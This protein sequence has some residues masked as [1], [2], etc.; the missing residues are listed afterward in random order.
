[1]KN[2]LARPVQLLAVI[3]LVALLVGFADTGV[4]WGQAP[5]PPASGG[6]IYYF[7]N[8]SA[9]GMPRVGLTCNGK[10]DSY[11]ERDFQPRE[12]LWVIG[13]ANQWVRLERSVSGSDIM[14]VG[15]PD[16]QA[17]EKRIPAT[18]DN[19]GVFKV[20]FNLTSEN[21][22]RLAVIYHVKLLT[23]NKRLTVAE[24]DI[25]PGVAF[26]L[27]MPFGVERDG[28]LDAFGF[29][30][31]SSGNLTTSFS[32]TLLAFY[33]V[34]ARPN[35]NDM[36]SDKQVPGK[37]QGGAAVDFEYRWRAVSTADTSSCQATGRWGSLT[38]AGLPDR[39]PDQDPSPFTSISRGYDGRL[40]AMPADFTGP[41]NPWTWR[42]P[43][44]MLGFTIDDPGLLAAKVTLNTTVGTTTAFIRLKSTERDRPSS[45]PKIN[46]RSP[47]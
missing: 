27:R 34:K 24:D 6:V 47:F 2:Q 37:L 13:E 30:P 33:S 38:I 18:P 26:R 16:L 11:G 1:M 42:V 17:I 36:L 40:R 12:V 19:D 7:V 46:L 45:P 39:L 8:G 23:P 44:D 20:R 35:P 32:S 21:T 22:G 14:F 10:E 25:G 29:A 15:T 4:A 41:L 9:W 3:G 31:S 5:R 28:D 43:A